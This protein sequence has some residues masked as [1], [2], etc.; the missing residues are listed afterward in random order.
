[1]QDKKRQIL[2][3]RKKMA[4]S[5]LSGILRCSWTP[6]GFLSPLGQMLEV[7]CW[8]VCFSLLAPSFVVGQAQTV[9]AVTGHIRGPGGVSVPG[10]TVQA[11]ELQSGERK[12]TWSDE[13]G[14]YTLSGLPPGTYRLEVSLVG[15]RTD[16]REPVPVAAGGS[17]KVNIALVMAL[18]EMSLPLRSQNG[19]NRGHNRAALPA[20]IPA[21]GANFSLGT[22]P[23]ETV[24]GNEVN[25]RL[26]EGSTS[27][28]QPQGETPVGQS[29]SSS[30]A[31]SFLLTGGVTRAPEPGEEDARWRQRVEE[32]RRA[33]ESQGAPGFGEAGP[34]GPLAIFMGGAGG[35][36]AQQ[37]ALV[38]RVR[39]NIV[40]QYSNSA[41][42]AHPYPLNAPQS[43]Q[44]PSY[45]EQLAFAIGG[46]LVIPKVY[47]G[48]DKTSFFVH[49]SL[50]H[51][52]DPF[53][54]FATVPT[55]AERAGDFS[56]AA[57][58]SGPLAGTIPV[59][60]NG[61]VGGGQLAGQRMP[62]PGNQILPS[63]FDPAAV[64]LLRF[65][66]SPNLPGG[67]QN[68]HLQEALPSS[69]DRLMARVGHRATSKDNLNVFYFLNS[70]RSDS[71]ANFPGFT[72]H[73]SL[74]S[75]NANLGETHTFSPRLVNQFLLNFNRQRNSLLNPFAFRQDIS[76]Q[77]GIQG[78]SND[79]RDWGLPLVQFTNFTGLNDAIPSLTRNQ[80][81]RVFDFLIWNSG[82]H[83]VRL[84]GEVRRVQL[85][86]LTDPDAR[87]TFTFTGFT[88]SD[89][90]QGFPVPGTGF[91][92][93]DFLLG[94]PQATSVRF[95]TSSNYF[96][97][98]VY[99]AFVQD[100]WR[101]SSRLTFNLGFRYEYFSPFTEK[102]GH[103]SDLVIGPNF[104]EVSVV[105]GQSPGSL[106][107]S[108]LRGDPNNF[109]P[110][111][112]LAF[113]PWTQRKLVFRAGYGIFFD[114]SIYPRL[115]PNLANQPPFA[116]AS[117]LLTN[118]KQVLTFEQGFPEIA[119]SVVKNTY[120]VDP[121][122]RT[123]Y[124][125]SWSFGIED[126]IARNVI[127]SITYTGTK[128][129][130]L[131]LLLGPNPGA[132]GSPLTTQER[133]ALRNALQFT[134]ET[135]GASSIYHGLQ[136]GLRRQFH[137]GLSMDVNYTFSKAID[138][139]ASVG[140]AGRTVAQ[141]FLDLAAERGLS[142][143]DVRHK[144][145]ARHIYEFPF[146]DG[147]RYLNRGGALGH[148]LGNWQISGGTTLQS[149][150]PF[151]ARVLGNQSNNGG[152]G[153]YFS[154]RA[155]ATGLP[156]SL[157]GFE[158]STQQFFNIGAFTLPPP[159]QFGNAGRNTIPGPRLVNF[160]MSL[161]R[162]VTFSREKG[163]R[164]EFRVEANNLMNT[165]DFTGLATVVNA[166]EYGRVT[167]VKPMRSLSF[168]MRIRF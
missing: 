55:P 27:P 69:N 153:A 134:Y 62:F 80:T 35:A 144:F 92:F 50:A 49:Y 70:A 31:N 18:P 2:V 12:V 100:D 46:P 98:W 32:F 66:P 135:S 23:A 156:V 40:E 77:L 117:I 108:L 39:G 152:T 110:R 112:G 22:N 150:T 45:R 63:S 116:E 104:S 155:D 25:V 131:D 5:A 129:T 167:S 143:F 28:E 54:S 68:F 97:S 79:P 113:R 43:S 151:T 121:N 88:T 26:A 11:V 59:V 51:N 126:A 81:L 17:L 82:K 29:D 119:L 147:H 47:H 65:I 8:L 13:S 128:G 61:G 125:Q 106:P 1:M 93:A 53:D 148:L 146:G 101:L 41:L 149:G 132:S 124:G 105:T 137:H 64:G 133:L 56:Q 138:D 166:S 168:T 76:G 75:Q 140:G 111:I 145:H 158:R 24:A 19:D 162:S 20:D 60:Y 38:N 74:L 94:F 67:V 57:I 6:R 83:N 154:Q 102:Y 114:G 107:R 90:E 48:A 159:G 96:R 10:A 103:L 142:V 118:P 139:A 3:V 84:G 16:V 36:W 164:G 165:P 85:N 58:P 72:R 15:F 91:D 42:N 73:S 160:D 122:F 109:A 161:A 87:G 89:F 37:R 141:N 21:Q 163:V 30:A 115:V 99:S 86:T 44:I 4:Q 9:G 33:R 120:A 71:V 7:V 14:N 157:P 34:G 130:K 52:R 78:V 136:I 127:L 95:G 123:P